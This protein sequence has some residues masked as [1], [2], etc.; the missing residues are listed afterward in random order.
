MFWVGFN[1]RNFIMGTNKI[2]FLG[3]SPIAVEFLLYYTFLNTYPPSPQSTP[4]DAQYL[5]GESFHRAT[6]SCASGFYSP[7]PDDICVKTCPSRFFGDANTAKTCLSCHYSCLTCS[8]PYT[9]TTC[10]T[11]DAGLRILNPT[12]SQCYCQAPKADNGKDLICLST[13]NCANYN[14]FN[15]CIACKSD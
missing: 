8:A 4:A 3:T 9:S 10:L 6:Q 2:N 15:Q 1:Y 5:Y 7:Y 11:C 12:S 13:T 14:K